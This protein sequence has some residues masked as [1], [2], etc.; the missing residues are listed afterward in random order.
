MLPNPRELSQAATH[1]FASNCDRAHPKVRKRGFPLMQVVDE[2]NSTL[3][4]RC[5]N[6]QNKFPF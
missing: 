4:Q 2:G 5:Q 1:A 6:L 3:L